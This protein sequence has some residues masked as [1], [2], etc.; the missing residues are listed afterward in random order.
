MARA[1]ASLVLGAWSVWIGHSDPFY[2]TAV[3]GK[4]TQGIPKFCILRD[5]YDETR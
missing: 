5:Q 2:W 3:Y 1:P 4:K